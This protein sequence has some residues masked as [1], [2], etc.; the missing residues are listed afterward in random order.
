[1]VSIHSRKTLTMTMLKK[2]FPASQLWCMQPSTR[3]AEAGRALEF[4]ASLFYRVSSGA[5]QRTLTFF[6]FFFFFFNP[7]QKKKKAFPTN[8]YPTMDVVCLCHHFPWM[9]STSRNLLV[10]TSLHLLWASPNDYICFSSHVLWEWNIIK[11]IS[12]ILRDWNICWISQLEWVV[13]LALRSLKTHD[14]GALLFI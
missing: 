11:I 4:E 2:T 5:T 3:E 10:K 8:R 1:M 13:H 9:L 6:F 7:N 12:V 14:C